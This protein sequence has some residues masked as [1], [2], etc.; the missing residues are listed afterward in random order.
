VRVISRKKI[1]EASKEHPEWEASLAAWYQI[2]KDKQ[3]NWANFVEVRQ[4]F[5]NADKVGE[6]VVFNI[7]YNKCRLV[8]W[9]KYKTKKV[10]IRAILTHSDYDREK[11]K[12][13]C[14]C[15]D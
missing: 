13:E 12:D 4:T 15:D 9:V 5:S 3:V 11:W 10:F 14:N 6:C 2:V 1:K 7:Q 8:S